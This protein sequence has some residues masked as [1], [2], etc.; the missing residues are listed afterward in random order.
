VTATPTHPDN[1]PAWAYG[2]WSH[3]GQLPAISVSYRGR[4]IK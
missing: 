1:Q 4:I 3:N 2:F